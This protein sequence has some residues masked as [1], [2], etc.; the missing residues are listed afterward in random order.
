MVG[1]GGCRLASAQEK[2][3]ALE[4]GM[5]DLGAFS[6]QKAEQVRAWVCVCVGVLWVEGWGWG[7]VGIPPSV[8]LSG[9]CKR[10][11]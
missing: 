6:Q 1:G 5:A 2:I 8:H 11:V 10:V 3:A 9:A 7:W 4:T